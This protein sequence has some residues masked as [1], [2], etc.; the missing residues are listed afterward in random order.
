[1]ASSERSAQ[2]R[3]AT[4]NVVAVYRTLEEARA[5]AAAL[6]QAGVPAP[7]LELMDRAG[8][9]A[10]G[11]APSGLEQPAVTRRVGRAARPSVPPSAGG[12]R[13]ARRARHPPHLRRRQ[14]RARD[15]RCHRRVGHRCRS[16]RVLRRG[17]RAASDRHVLRRPDPAQRRGRACRRV[18]SGRTSCHDTR[19]DLARTARSLRAGRPPAPGLGLRIGSSARRVTARLEAVAH[20]RLGDEVAGLGRVGLQLAPE[21]GEVH[22]RGRTSRCRS[23]GPRPAGAATVG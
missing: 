21:A 23:A 1:M 2:E 4:Y 9:P 6:G 15:R 18:R 3:Y 20:A 16:R 5:A 8:A 12:R 22:A 11:G 19:A 14:H 17:V 10:R 7:N 13:S